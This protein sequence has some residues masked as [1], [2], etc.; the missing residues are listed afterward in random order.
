MPHL[1][2]QPLPH[3]LV[4]LVSPYL[5]H[6]IGLGPV[7][8][9]ESRHQVEKLVWSVK[10]SKKNTVV[11][12]PVNPIMFYRHLQSFFTEKIDDVCTV[13]EQKVQSPDLDNDE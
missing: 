5:S 6:N 9:L 11:S 4:L 12:F 10:L 13:S 3:C 8:D 1:C 2:T 7:L